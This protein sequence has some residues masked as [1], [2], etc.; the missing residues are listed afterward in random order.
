[1]VMPSEMERHGTRSANA[2][3]HAF[4]Q[5]AQVIVAWTDFNPGVGHA[6]ERLLKVVVVHAGGSQH[7]AG[8][9]TVGAV[10]QSVAARAGKRFSHSDAFSNLD[11]TTKRV[12]NS[13]RQL[14]SIPHAHQDCRANE[15][16]RK[17]A[18]VP[19]NTFASK[20]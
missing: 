14:S 10:H 7:G 17:T 6:N 20:D 1:M 18:I 5:L 11:V 8:R 19:I 12:Q 15:H 9:R 16:E 3:F 13:G 4:G 2:L